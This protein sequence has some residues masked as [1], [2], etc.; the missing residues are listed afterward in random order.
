MLTNLLAPDELADK[1]FDEIVKV[2]KDHFELPVLTVGER[3][4]FYC[5]LQTETESVIDFI[6]ALK[7]LLLT[8][9]F[10]THLQDALRY[11][12][13]AGLRSDV[14]KRRLLVEANL[15]FD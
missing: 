1:S 10:K 5:R 6:A 11:Q 9:S 3:L 4:K 8:C 2:F 15:T 7:K 12:F 14:I 13:V